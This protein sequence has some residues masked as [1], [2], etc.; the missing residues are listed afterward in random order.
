MRRTPLERL[1]ALASEDLRVQAREETKRRILGLWGRLDAFQKRVGRRVK[2]I[3]GLAAAGSALYGALHNPLVD[4]LVALYRAR[5][6]GSA[7]LPKTGI[8]ST[9]EDFVTKPP[10][11]R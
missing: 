10:G 9:A 3:T 8:A 5:S 4:K 1:R 11:K 6:V 7:E 2:T